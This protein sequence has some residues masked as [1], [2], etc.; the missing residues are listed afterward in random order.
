MAAMTILGIA[1][2][3]SKPPL[4]KGYYTREPWKEGTMEDAEFQVAAGTTIP[5]F[6]YSRHASKDGT[7]RT[8]MMVGRNPFVATL[9]GSKI[10]TVIVPVKITIGSTTYNPV[11]GN[12]CDGSVSTVHRLHSSPL[13]TASSLTFNGVSVGTY[14]YIDG[15]RRA[16][17]WSKVGGSAAYTNSLSPVTVAAVQSLTAGT[18]GIN[19]SSGCTGLGIVSNSWISGQLLTLLANLT[20][21]GVVGPTKFV[22]FLLDNVV[23]SLDDPPDVTN[24]C[25]L[26]FHSATGSPVQTYGITDWDTTGDFGTGIVDGSISAHEIGEWMDDPLVTNATPAWG[27]IGQVSGC[28][29]NLEVGDPLTGTNM[30]GIT[31]GGFTYHMQELGF[32]SWYFNSEFAASLGAGGKFSG[33]GTFAGPSKVCPPGGTF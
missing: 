28:Q 21:S 15:F 27:G 17:F 20:T 10:P 31:L 7:T 22:L 18:H 8:G 32:F 14:Q 13:F 25:I 30:P 4:L 33:N 2:D 1:Q 23:Q 24:C 11:V 3:A 6:S 16:E 19:Y 12:P 29:L 26:G 5:M 9:S